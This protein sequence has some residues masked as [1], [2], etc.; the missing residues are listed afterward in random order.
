MLTKAGIEWCLETLPRTGNMA[1]VL[2]AAIREDLPVGF[3]SDV[4]ARQLGTDKTADG[5]FL[6]FGAVR[7]AIP[8]LT[9]VERLGEVLSDRHILQLH[10]ESVLGT[11][12]GSPLCPGGAVIPVFPKEDYIVEPGQEEI[13]IGL[14]NFPTGPPWLTFI[15]SACSGRAQKGIGIS[16]RDLGPVSVQGDTMAVFRDQVVPGDAPIGHIKL[17]L[18]GLQHPVLISSH[19][20]V[21]KVVPFV[22]GDDL[23]PR[24]IDLVGEPPTELD[25]QWVP[26]RAA[27]EFLKMAADGAFHTVQF[28]AQPALRR[29]A[30]AQ[31]NGQLLFDTLTLPD[32]APTSYFRVNSHEDIRPDRVT[33]GEAE[34]YH[35]L[36]GDALAMFA[37]TWDNVALGVNAF[38]GGSFV[39]RPWSENRPVLEFSGRVNQVYLDLGLELSMAVHLVRTTGQCDFHRSR[40]HGRWFA[41]RSE[42]YAGAVTR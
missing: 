22:G 14:R 15:L 13:E 19:R 35:K 42:Q 12:D 38:T 25:D 40:F 16:P 11:Y 18:V 5:M 28:G 21:F 26:V 23:G 41:Q 1:D 29:T 27:L 6:P 36:P 4:V 24:S 3:V 34:V 20:P 33:L 10:E 8:R 31:G 32:C 9:Q 7:R 39:S 17:H 30:Q 2:V 37:N